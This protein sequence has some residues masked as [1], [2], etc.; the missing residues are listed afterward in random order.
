MAGRRGHGRTRE[1]QAGGVGGIDRSETQRQGLSHACPHSRSRTPRHTTPQIK[2]CR[3]LP[4][5]C[6][7]ETLQPR[8]P[9][10]FCRAC[11]SAPAAALH[12]GP[13]ASTRRRTNL[14]PQP[15]ESPHQRR[16]RLRTSM[17]RGM[18]VAARQASGSER[19]RRRAKGILTVAEVREG[20]RAVV[21]V[22]QVV[23]DLRPAAHRPPARTDTRTHTCAD[24]Q[25]QAHTEAGTDVHDSTARKRSHAPH[26]R[27]GRALRSPTRAARGGALTCWATRRWGPSSHPGGWGCP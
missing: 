22:L 2:G 4:R 24:T 7:P 6:A 12:S 16:P 5:H 11:A 27:S 15:H 18:S 17:H 3:R 25:T 26:A 19:A 10:Q 23:V 13:R 20:G 9:F 21:H 8:R 14:P 1:S